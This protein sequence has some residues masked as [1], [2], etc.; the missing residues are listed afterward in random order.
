MAK[1]TKF[2]KFRDLYEV[3]EELAVS[4]TYEGVVEI[5]AERHD[6]ILT[7]GTLTNYLYRYRKESKKSSVSTDNSNGKVEIKHEASGQTFVDLKGGEPIQESDT[8]IDDDSKSD[9]QDVE[10]IDYDA[11]LEEMKR[12]AAIKSNRS[13]LDR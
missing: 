5:L 12:K 10:E 6:L 4:Y 7:T 9:E 1:R 3:I 8:D 13:L 11:L 2:S